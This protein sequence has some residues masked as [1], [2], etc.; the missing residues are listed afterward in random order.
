M[1]MLIQHT[2][3]FLTDQQLEMT[4]NKC[5]EHLERSDQRKKQTD[6]HKDEEDFDED[7]E[8]VLEMEKNME[9]EFHC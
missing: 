4:Y 3:E 9:N 8:G 6:E 5:I 2:G 7:V 1:Q